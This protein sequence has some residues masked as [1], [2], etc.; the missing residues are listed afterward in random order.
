M[1]WISII[2]ILGFIRGLYYVFVESKNENIYLRLS[3]FLFNFINLFAVLY[4]IGLLDY[5]LYIKKEFIYIYILCSVGLLLYGKKLK[6]S[7]STKNEKYINMKDSL[8][9]IV[10]IL[11]YIILQYY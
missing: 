6:L 7:S 9:I 8:V 2:C 11:A 5:K 1:K 10:L 4:L 3:A